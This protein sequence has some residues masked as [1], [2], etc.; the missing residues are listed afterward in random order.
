MYDKLFDATLLNLWRGAKIATGLYGADA[1]KAGLKDPKLA[2]RGLEPRHVLAKLGDFRAV[3]RQA[4]GL[5][6]ADRR[7]HDDTAGFGR[8]HETLEERCE[9]GVSASAIRRSINAS[10][11]R[12]GE[13]AVFRAACFRVDRS[14]ATLGAWMIVRHLSKSFASWRGRYVGLNANGLGEGV[15]GRGELP[16]AIQPPSLL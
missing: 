6:V 16:R 14:F 15:R 7:G 5:P 1:A 10:F 11:H 2:G 3:A 12:P 13:D 4:A 8:R 9:V